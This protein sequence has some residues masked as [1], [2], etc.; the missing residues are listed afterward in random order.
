VVALNRGNAPSSRFI[1]VQ[2]DQPAEAPQKPLASQ[3]AGSDTSPQ[4]VELDSKREAPKR[5]EVDPATRIADSFKR[6]KKAVV[7]C[8]NEH[9]DEAE[10]TPK[11]AVRIALE[12]GGHV[13]TAKVSPASV[14][15]GTLGTCIERAVR[16]MQFPR[17]TAAL[18]FEVPLTTRKGD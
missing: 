2:A 18:S 6:Q 1:L 14:A 15:G 10:H 8:L 4:K 7:S 17:Q 9:Y 11:L 5:V 13:Q 16:A 3:V 12:A